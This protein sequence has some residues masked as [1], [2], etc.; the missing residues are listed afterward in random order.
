MTN[1]QV[2]VADLAASLFTVNAA[3]ANMINFT[4]PGWGFPREVSKT[5]PFVHFLQDGKVVGSTGCNRF[6]RTY[7]QN[8]SA[9]T[10]GTLATTRRACLRQPR[11]REQQVLDALSR[12]RVV[13]RAIL[14][15]RSRTRTR[16]RM[17]KF[18]P[19]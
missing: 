1:S 12:T 11:K 16:T 15:S 7:S 19:N 17:K 6:N 5:A 9:L 10:I 8:G 13:K 4:G 3:E 2:L 18:L 14:R